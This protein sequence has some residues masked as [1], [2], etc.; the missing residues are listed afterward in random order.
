[1]L[2]FFLLTPKCPELLCKKK[3]KKKKSIHW[4]V[5]LIFLSEYLHTSPPQ[6]HRSLQAVYLSQGPLRRPPS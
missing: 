3:K 4:L 2:G 5:L 1:M 6:E